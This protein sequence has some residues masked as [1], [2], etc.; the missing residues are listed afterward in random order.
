MTK[1]NKASLLLQNTEVKNIVL[2]YG[3]T[4][5]NLKSYFQ[6]LLNNHTLTIRSLAINILMAKPF[7]KPLKLI[8]LDYINFF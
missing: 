5:M 3:L 6:I 7:G 1:T 2:F 4:K 8:L